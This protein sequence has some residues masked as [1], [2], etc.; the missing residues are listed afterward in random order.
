M[1]QNDLI[2]TAIGTGDLLYDLQRTRLIFSACWENFDKVFSL[3]LTDE[4]MDALNNAMYLL[5][6]YETISDKAMADL[7][8]G[9]EE[10]MEM[11]RQ[12]YE[13]E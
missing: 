10:L 7:T 3:G 12:R 9:L 6:V 8:Q 1:S 4:Q 2:R 5:T 11:A 13:R